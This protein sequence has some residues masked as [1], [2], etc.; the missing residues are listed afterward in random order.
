[1]YQQIA[2]SVDCRDSNELFDHLFLSEKTGESIP[3]N[4]TIQ[5]RDGVFDSTQL[6]AVY[7]TKDVEKLIERL[8]EAQHAVST[9]SR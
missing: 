2:L 9:S 4:F 8:K 7:E 6:Y 1:M 3:M 5:S